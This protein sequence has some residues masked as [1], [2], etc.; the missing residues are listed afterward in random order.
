MGL[1]KNETFSGSP[2][3]K[4]SELQQDGKISIIPKQE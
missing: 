4:L 1:P 3:K 2:R